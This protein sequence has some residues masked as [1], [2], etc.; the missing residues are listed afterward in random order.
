[1]V[2]LFLEREAVL[3]AHDEGELLV[4]LQ[5]LKSRPQ[6]GRGMVRRAGETIA[7]HAGASRKTLDALRPLIEGCGVQPGAARTASVMGAPR[8]TVT[9]SYRLSALSC[10]PEESRAES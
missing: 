1:V 5:T 9:E 6:V 4:H 3:V 8:S 7:L 10:Q 2:T